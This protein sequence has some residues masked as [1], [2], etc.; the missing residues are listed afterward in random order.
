MLKNKKPKILVI[1]EISHIKDLK[2]FF[3]SFGNCKFL[4]NPDYVDVLKIISQFD[5]IFTN[6]NK[7]KVMIDKKLLDHAN[8]L[9]IICT[10]STGTN[11]I[12]VDYAKK[13][14]IKVLSLKNQKRIINKISS[15]AELAFTF[16]LLSIRKVFQANQSVKSGLWDYTNFIGRQMNGLNIGIIGY[17]RLGKFF[18]KFCKIFNSN[19]IVFD[20]YKKVYDKRI[21][22]VKNLDNLLLKSDVISIHVHLNKETTNMINKKSF[23]KMKK[24]V[25]LI[26]TSRGEVVNENYLIKILKKNKNMFYYTDVISSEIKNNKNSNLIK[27]SKEN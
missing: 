25:I 4:D 1:T 17:G 15:T 12:D 18:V 11:H 14:K 23:L 8:N 5:A 21:A 20:P 16:L 19:I 6:P 24:N 10:A 7:S 26:N 27:E 3:K 13:K 9:K 22:Q 2:Y